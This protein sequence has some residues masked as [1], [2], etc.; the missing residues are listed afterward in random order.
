VAHKLA[1]SERG[2]AE[3]RLKIGD[4]EALGDLAH[5]GRAAE[6]SKGLRFRRKL[7]VEAR[8]RGLVIGLDRPHSDRRAI[9]QDQRRVGRAG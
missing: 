3:L 5:I 7:S 1:A 9:T 2:E 6:E 8:E 4:G